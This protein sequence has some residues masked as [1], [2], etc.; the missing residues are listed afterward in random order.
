MR[1]IFDVT[2]DLNAQR[3]VITCITDAECV[4]PIQ[5][6]VVPQIVFIE[7]GIPSSAALDQYAA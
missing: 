7:T 4:R 3:N 5:L 6:W 2:A 1:V